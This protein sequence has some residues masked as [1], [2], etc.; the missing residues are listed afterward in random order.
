VKEGVKDVL[1]AIADAIKA[2][3]GATGW[4]SVKLGKL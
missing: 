4:S 2:E 1:K 3:D